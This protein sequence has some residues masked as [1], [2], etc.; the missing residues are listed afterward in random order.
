LRRQYRA[1][2]KEP[3]CLLGKQ[4]RMAYTLSLETPVI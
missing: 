3:V 1:G 2:L 4:K